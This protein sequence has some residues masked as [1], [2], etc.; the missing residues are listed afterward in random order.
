MELNSKLTLANNVWPSG[1]EKLASEASMV[2]AVDKS[3][4][5]QAS[6]AMGGGGYVIRLQLLGLQG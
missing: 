4:V 3:M 5:P 1:L 2:P 6:I